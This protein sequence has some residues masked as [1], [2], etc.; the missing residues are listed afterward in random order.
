LPKLDSNAQK[1]KWCKALIEHKSACFVP[2]WPLE[3]AALPGWIKQRLSASAIRIDN[4]A[5]ELLAARVE[6]NLL[7][8]AQEIE[9]LKLLAGSGTLTFDTVQAAVA[10]SARFDVFGLIDSALA[11]DTAHALRTLQGLRREG[12]ES[13][14]VL[15]ALARELRVL[16]TLAAD[17]T[18]AFASIRP[19]IHEKRRLLLSRALQRKPAL[20]LMLVQA[21]QIDAQIKGQAAGDPWMGLTDLCL[22]LC[23]KPLNLPQSH[24]A[25]FPITH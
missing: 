17:G 15:W 4:D 6:G 9:K 14:V 20:S 3:T 11:G 23:G 22:Q 21:A 1:S 8:A 7:A 13:V 2:I 10:D 24:A 5:V 19:P 16:G 12:V 18:N 25:G